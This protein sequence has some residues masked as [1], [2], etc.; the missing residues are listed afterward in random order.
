IYAEFQEAP[1]SISHLNPSQAQ[2]LAIRL[3]EAGLNIIKRK[4]GRARRL[5]I[6]LNDL[7]RELNRM[8]QKAY[9]DDILQ[10]ALAAIN[11]N[12]NFFSNDL[13]D[14]IR[15]QKWEELAEIPE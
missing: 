6:N 2:E 4:T 10:M 8:G 7:R 12:L 15:G 11:M 5:S 13:R 3:S 14:V 9:D 1:S